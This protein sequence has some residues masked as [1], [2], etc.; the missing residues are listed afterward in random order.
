MNDKARTKSIKDKYTG[1]V[2]CDG[3]YRAYLKIGVQQFF[4]C[5]PRSKR[6]ANWY[7]DMLTIALCN[8]LTGA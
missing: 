5:E 2:R 8:L 1:L 7:R 3:G 4:V 6:E